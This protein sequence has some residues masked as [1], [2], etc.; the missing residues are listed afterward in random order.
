[1]K[2]LNLYQDYFY[3]KN[4]IRPSKSL[5]FKTLPLVMLCLLIVS[6]FTLVR[7]RTYSGVDI[8]S[9]KDTIA[10]VMN[11][12]DIVVGDVTYREA[13]IAKERLLM[14]LDN[15]NKYDQELAYQ[16][17]VE[18]LNANFQI[19]DWI[20]ITWWGNIANGPDAP[21]DASCTGQI[22]HISGDTIYGTWGEYPLK[23]KNAC[24]QRIKKSEYLDLRAIEQRRRDRQNRK[25]NYG[26]WGVR[27]PGSYSENTKERV[28]W[29]N[30]EVY[31]REKKK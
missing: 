27:M 24:W 4:N 3:A 1:M 23:Y 28:W 14:F 11:D 10:A 15:K 18:E 2:Y 6:I 29:D 17:L 31:A 9:D 7:I 26:L 12:N 25:K 21:S 19:G 20:K 5:G 22:K 16:E 30:P 8:K 13:K